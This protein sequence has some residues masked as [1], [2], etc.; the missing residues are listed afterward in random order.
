MEFQVF[1]DGKIVDDF[2]LHGAYLFGT[3][4]IAIRRAQISFNKG[5][6]T[7]VKP[8]LETAGLALLW[9]VDGF[10]R[11][12]LPTTCLPERAQPY[13]LNV[14]LARAKLMQIVNKR[15]DWAFFDNI[16]GLEE[17]ITE[18][19]ELFIEAIQHISDSSRASRLAD[20]SLKKATVS[21]E[22]LAIRQAESL[23]VERGRSHNFGR[24][25]LGCR[26]NPGQVSEAKYFENLLDLFGFVTIPVNWGQIETHRG[27]YNYSSVDACINIL[28]RKRLAMCAGPLLRFTKEH[29]PGWL[30]QSGVG[31]EKVREAAYRFVS[32]TVAR[33]AGSIHAWRVISGMNLFND[34]GFSFEQ[35]LEMTRTANM[36]VRQRSDRVLKIVEISDPWGEYYATA[37]GTIPPLVYVDM[38]VQSGIS[39][40]AFGLELRVGRDEAGMHVRDMMQISSVL[41]YFGAVGK[42]LYITELEVPSEGGGG[43]QEMEAAGEWHRPWD[44]LR[45]ARWIEQFYKIALSKPFVEA[46]TYAHLTDVGDS[47]AARSGLL[48]AEFGV[49]KSFQVL[50]K[51]QEFIFN[52]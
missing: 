1:K 37:P 43:S 42:S 38:V 33:Y 51:L 39:F 17:S 8:N 50:K 47:A 4:G 7:C 16:D 27:N 22:K 3:D 21:S 36:A 10:G 28:A 15:E 6:I 9:P 44:Q 46:V 45:Q 11:V 18:A 29:V 23:F 41:D 20:E 30:L 2:A 34:F 13:N 19:R 31:F 48:T 25:C 40:D 12:L 24:G 35:I 52:R 49:K 26:V 32:R 14:E 5:V